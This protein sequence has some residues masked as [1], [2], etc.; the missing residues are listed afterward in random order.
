M[1]LGLVIKLNKSKKTISKEFDDG[2]RNLGRHCHFPIYSQFW[3]NPEARFW[4]H[5]L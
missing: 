2:V 5:S 4:A 3:S 1:K